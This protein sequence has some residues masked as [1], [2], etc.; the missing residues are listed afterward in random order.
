MLKTFSKGGVHPE[1]NKISEHNKIREIEIPKQVQIFVSQHIGVPAEV[2]VQKGDYVKAGQLIAKA[3]G[4]VSANVHSSVS[5]KINKIDTTTDVNGYKQTAIF[6]DVEGDEW[7]ED[8]DRSPEIVKNYDNLSAEEIRN[9]IAAA[10]I[11]GSGGATFPTHVKLSIPQG[12]SCNYLLINGVECEPYLTSDHQMMLEHPEEILIGCKLVQKATGAKEIIIGI[13]NNK[14]DAVALLSKKAKSF[15]GISVVALKMKYPQG[16]EK[17]LIKA[18]TKREV[19]SGK[20]PIEVGCVVQNA[21]TIFAIYEAVLKN[22]AFFERVVT[23][24]GKSLEKPSNIKARIGTPIKNLIDDCGGCPENTGKIISGGP[25]M[26]KAIVND[27][28]PITK[29]SSGILLM[30]ENISKRRRESHC[31]RCA[32]CV[33]ACPMGL[34]PFLLRNLSVNNLTEDLHKERVLDCVECGCCSFTC[35]ANIPL[36]DHIRIAKANVNKL[37]RSKK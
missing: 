28:I 15:P 32:K 37:L 10:G 4:F 12:K 27:N 8:I 3:N 2:I 13:E 25:M 21:G 7:L 18:L 30:P 29:G 19:P 1:E 33:S 34:E 17:Q 26:G 14:K 16:A 9:K 6:I 31:I 24:T 23:V 5:G 22:K 36:L 20:L 35:P 11:V